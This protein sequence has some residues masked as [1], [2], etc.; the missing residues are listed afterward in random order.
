MPFICSNCN[1]WVSIDDLPKK[2]EKPAPVYVG[3]ACPHC[4]FDTEV[5]TKDL[6]DQFPLKDLVCP[7]CGKVIFLTKPEV[8]KSTYGWYGRGGFE[9]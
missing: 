9:D 2:D 8:K 3:M 5:L 6:L 4:N 1:K 7:S